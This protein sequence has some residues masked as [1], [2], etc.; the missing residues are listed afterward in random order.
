M[1]TYRASKILFYR[2]YVDDTFC[3]FETEH[4]A[5]LFFDFINTRH[6]NIRFTMEKEVDHKL[7]FLDVFIHNHS[8][9]PTTTVFRKK[10]FTGLLT[11]YFSFTAF[12]YKIGLV[13]ALI[14]KPSKI[15]NKWSGFHNDVKHLTFILRKNLFPTHLI[16]KVLNRCITRA[17]TPSSDGDQV[18][19]S[20]TVKYFKL[21]YVGPFSTVAQRRLRKLVKQFCFDLDIKLAFSSFK[22]RN[23]FSVKDPVP[24]HLRSRVVYQFT[25]AG[26]NACYVG[27]TFRH[28]STRIR[29]HLG[30]DRTSHI[31]HHLQNSDECRRLS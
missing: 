29:E 31:F 9:G 1:E 24:F 27:E 17:Q 5:L 4:D 6:P 22:I 14:H 3:V 19:S 7:P 10:T 12:S 13:R 2:R 8:P 23:M 20:V 26:C 28:I 21:P 25:C 15:N 18:Q 11:N 30:R 16:D